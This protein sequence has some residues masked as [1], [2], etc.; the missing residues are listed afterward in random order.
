MSA[1]VKKWINR[2]GLIAM[3]AGIVMIVAAG[4]D[5]TVAIGTVGTVAEIVGAIA[6]LLRELFN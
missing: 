5:T 4:G 2:G 3:I 1:N 6:V